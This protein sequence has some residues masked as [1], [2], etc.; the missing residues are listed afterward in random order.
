MPGNILFDVFNFLVLIIKDMGYLGIFLG[1]MIES[2]IFPLPSELILIPAGALVATGEMTFPLVFLTAVAGTIIGAMINFL[3]AMFLGRGLV[4][5]LVKKYG[6]FLFLT[7]ARL[8]KTDVFFNKHGEIT[9][10]IGRLIPV[11]RHIISLPAGFSRMNVFKFIIY[12]ALGAGIWSAF[13]I[14]LGYLFWDRLEWIN[15]HL[16]SI[17]IPVLIL[18][19]IIVII[20]ILIHKNHHKDNSR[21]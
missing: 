9:T 14:Y 10:F 4:N 11:A 16:N 8:R 15:V 17:Y 19:L 1:M 2:T 6:R 7:E 5:M 3:F 21:K 12:T 18:V 13:L 20:Y